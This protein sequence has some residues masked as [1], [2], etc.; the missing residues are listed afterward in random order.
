MCYS[1]YLHF[2]LLVSNPHFICVALISS[3]SQSDL[4]IG[5]NLPTFVICINKLPSFLLNLTSLTSVW[6]LSFLFW[7]IFQI[8][9]IGFVTYSNWIIRYV[10]E[11]YLFVSILRL[12]VNI[13]FLYWILT[14]LYNCVLD[15]LAGYNYS[16]CFSFSFTRVFIIFVCV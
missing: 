1:H 5:F 2:L 6:F 16:V 14:S 8:R 10:L 7:L 3:F 15:N 13:L 11:I 12:G 9:S 4:H